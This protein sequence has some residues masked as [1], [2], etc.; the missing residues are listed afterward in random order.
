MTQ[1]IHTSTA[2]IMGEVTTPKLAQKLEKTK[3][4]SNKIKP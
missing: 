2:N 3:Q 1:E 4:E